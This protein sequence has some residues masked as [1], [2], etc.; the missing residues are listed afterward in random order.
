MAYP[1]QQLQK[2]PTIKTDRYICSTPSIK[3]LQLN[4]GFSEG[5]SANLGNAVSI[6]PL[7]GIMKFNI[8]KTK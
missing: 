4:S 2:Y 5:N 3:T 8:I 7:P 1:A 6:V